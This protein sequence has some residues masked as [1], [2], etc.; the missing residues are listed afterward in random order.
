MS[1][2]STFAATSAAVIALVACSSNTMPTSP[3]SPPPAPT[4]TPAPPPTANGFVLAGVAREAGPG[5]PALS[6]V[7]V[8][9]VRGADAGAASM[10]DNGGSFR[11]DGVN[12]VV[13]VE[14]TKSGFIV[15]RVENLTVDH[16]MSLDVVLYPM[17][18]T[19]AAGETATARCNDG[20]WSWAHTVG[21]ACTANGG[22]M[23]GVCPG[24][25]CAATRGIR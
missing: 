15:W 3:G 6:S 25:L 20:S 18:P 8:A 9:I 11:L 17:P 24:I 7:R 16:D 21:E 22:I 14:A 13:D 10:T 12:G 5:S 23:Y 19:N 4:P 1:R 2:F